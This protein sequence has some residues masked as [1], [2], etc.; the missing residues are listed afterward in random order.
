LAW[1]VEFSEGAKKD[2]KNLD[3]QIARRILKF[4]RER[5]ET[6]EDPRR[7]GDCLEGSRLGDFWK[8]RAGDWRMVCHIQDGRVMILVLK[9]G[10]RSTVYREK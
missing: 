2:L 5:L 3:P 6:D 7:L 4:V 9:I 8:Y 1:K 10:H